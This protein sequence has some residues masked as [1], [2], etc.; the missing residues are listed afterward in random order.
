MYLRPNAYTVSRGVSHS[1]QAEAEGDIVTLTST[2]GDSSIT[3]TGRYRW[4]L[5]GDR[6]HFELVGRDECGGRAEH[7]EDATYEWSG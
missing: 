1:G 3:G 2:C 5:S 6:L 7:L 4:T